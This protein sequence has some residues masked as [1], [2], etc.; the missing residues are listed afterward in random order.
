[1]MPLTNDGFA[2]YTLLKSI[3][4]RLGIIIFLA[5]IGIITKWIQLIIKK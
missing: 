2:L 1:M 3:N 4:V 5:I